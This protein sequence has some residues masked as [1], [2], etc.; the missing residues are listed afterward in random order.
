MA[1]TVNGVASITADTQRERINV[2]MNQALRTITPG[3]VLRARISYDT[4][5]DYV[6]DDP[7]VA[8]PM[9][10]GTGT[11]GQCI[12]VL[13]YSFTNA[14]LT[15]VTFKSKVGAAA[16]IALDAVTNTAN[17]AVAY[18]MYSGQVVTITDN[19]GALLISATGVLSPLTGVIY[20]VICD[21]IEMKA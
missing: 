17:S 4:S 21:R 5:G 10:T 18:S 11:G 12:A 6:I 19:G 8:N 16:A 7:T 14:A 20:Y 1:N 3:L 13:G 15:T 9:I 2:N